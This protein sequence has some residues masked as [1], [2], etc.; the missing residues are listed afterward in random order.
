MSNDN[1][2][3][4]ELAFNNRNEYFL[5]KD[6]Y[7]S[8]VKI[9]FL[10]LKSNGS[11][12]EKINGDNSMSSS[13]SYINK[14]ENSPISFMANIIGTR[15]SALQTMKEGNDSSTRKEWQDIKDQNFQVFDLNDVI[16]KYGDQP[17]LLQLILSSKLE[18]DRRKAEEAKLRQKE[19]DYYLLDAV[20]ENCYWNLITSYSTA[21]RHELV[22]NE[23][24]KQAKRKRQEESQ[25]SRE[26]G[27]F[28]FSSSHL[29]S[30]QPSLSGAQNYQYSVSNQMLSPSNA[31]AIELNGYN[32]K[33]TDATLVQLHSLNQNT[34]QKAT[35]NKVLTDKTIAHNNDS[36]KPVADTISENTLPPIDALSHAHNPDKSQIMAFSPLSQEQ[37]P[38]HLALFNNH[39]SKNEIDNK[40]PREYSTLDLFQESIMETLP[41]NNKSSTSSY[42]S[43]EKAE[44]PQCTHATRVEPKKNQ[45]FNNSSPDHK[46]QL[47][48]TTNTIVDSPLDENKDFTGNY[49]NSLKKM[50]LPPTHRSTSHTSLNSPVRQSRRRK[51]MQ[52]LTMIIETKEFPYDDKHAWKNNGNTVHKKTG[53]KSI[54]YKCYN[55]TMGCPVNKTVTFRENGEYLIK[56]RGNHIDYCNR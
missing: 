15:S 55:S 29:S 7:N 18:E 49:F 13:E 36:S 48:T 32:K 6:E 52:A 23:E 5:D 30:A 11:L 8:T 26:E 44:N 50:P 1:Y 46:D 35:Y 20:P 17:E 4:Q 28:S 27:G 38:I 22:N 16:K 24:Q 41:L 12:V 53:Y 56:Y 14:N 31:A 3:N 47:N 21:S 42:S 34:L 39:R 10:Q 2:F 9:D 33:L 25:S 43:P 45:T 19:L 40:K 54:Y 37:D 51:E